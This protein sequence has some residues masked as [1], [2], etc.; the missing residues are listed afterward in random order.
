MTPPACQTCR[1]PMR[2]LEA[3][4][5]RDRLDQSGLCFLPAESFE[6]VTRDCAARRV[7]T[8]VRTGEPARPY[9]IATEVR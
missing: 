5:T 9:P 1:A 4:E 3:D 8:T 6:C 7:V 2:R